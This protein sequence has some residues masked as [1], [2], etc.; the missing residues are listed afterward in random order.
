MAASVEENSAPADIASMTKVQK[1]AA[2]LV[3]LGPESAA[4]LM[5]HLDEY[6][7]GAV[8]AE[9]AKLTMIDQKLQRDLLREFSEV[10][11]QASTSIRGGLNYTRQTLEKSIGSYRATDLMSRI[12]PARATA[13]AMDEITAMEPAQVFNL[14]KSEQPQTIALILGHLPPARS[15]QVLVLLPPEQRQ[16]VVERLATLA[17]TPVEI[18]EQVVVVLK[19]K[20]GQVHTRALNRAGGVKSAADLLNALDKDASKPLLIGLEESNPDLGA[21]IR[22]KMFIFE[23]LSLL[24]PASLQ[25]IM[26]EVDMQDLAVGLKTASD[27]LKTVLLACIS[28]RAAETV[29]EEMSLMGAVKLR[30]IEA[31]QL[32]I[33]EI[34][35]KL[36]S[37]GEIEIDHGNAKSNASAAA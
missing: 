2:L 26:R 36:E 29:R 6:E 11:V 9:M 19:R 16:P 25:K 32:R 5:K 7:L 15:S 14:I 31:A 12:A 22:Q 10:A 35:R 4:G 30:D 21:A 17:P 34:V 20:L 37:A 3:V 27:K 33:I 8:S 13:G 23:D 28:R 1:L 18:V 24:D